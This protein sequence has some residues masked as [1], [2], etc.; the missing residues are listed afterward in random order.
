MSRPNPQ[1]EAVAPGLKIAVGAA[2]IAL[3]AVGAWFAWSFFGKGTGGPVAEVAQ[4]AAEPVEAITDTR[5]LLDSAR[6]AV[7]E[8]RIVEPQGNN[9]I[10]LYLRLLELEPDNRAARTALLE[11]MPYATD[12]ADRL[13]GRQQFD[14]A[15]RAIALLNE[16]DPGSTIIATLASRLQRTRAQSEAQQL[17]QEE[18]RQQ[19]ERDRLAAQQAAQQAA[20]APQAAPPSAAPAPAV[21]ATDTPSPPPGAA[22]A[23]P[24]PATATPA[25]P[26]TPAPAVAAAPAPPAAAAPSNPQ[27][28]DFE[29]IRR[30]NPQ[31]PQKA[32]R[33][34]LQGWVDL[35][36]T[37]TETGDVTDVQVVNAQPRREFDREAVRALQQWK[38]RPRIENGRPVPATAQ[39]R[40]E[41]KLSG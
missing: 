32:L 31:Y 25:A 21:A 1:A 18:A 36:F 33:Q 20:Q 14:A 13:I 30:I 39:Q 35:R 8:Q 26:A 17:A 7:G 12:A 19:A 41:F 22:P 27:T 40:L 6:Q 16:A 9:A 15:E 10:E 38:F 24:P 37:I 11:L 23:T 5:R 29:L 34:G 3:V 28:R 2:L 4:V